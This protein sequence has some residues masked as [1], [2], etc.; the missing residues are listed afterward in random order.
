MHISRTKGHSLNIMMSEL[1]SPFFKLTFRLF[2]KPLMRAPTW[3][4]FYVEYFR[5]NPSQKNAAVSGTRNL[6]KA[7]LYS[8]NTL[9]KR[10]AG[11]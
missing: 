10:V 1:Q 11:V 6:E 9:A 8:Q 5:A 3:A 7:Q 2:R 4:H